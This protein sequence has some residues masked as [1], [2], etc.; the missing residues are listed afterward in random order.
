M[1]WLNSKLSAHSELLIELISVGA[2]GPEHTTEIDMYAPT[3][4]NESHR[5]FRQECA[6]LFNDKY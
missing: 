4:D 1:Q 3:Q 5:V 2:G 6:N